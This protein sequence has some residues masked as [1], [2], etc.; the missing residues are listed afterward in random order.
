MIVIT[1]LIYTDKETLPILYGRLKDLC[2]PSRDEDGCE[3]YH[4]A[5][6]DEEN[7]TILAMEGWRDM[8][9]LETHLALPAVAKLLADFDG[10]YTNAVQI[11]Q[12]SSSQKI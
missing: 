6:E 3:F 9:A 8:A 12:V 4:M 10:K 5:M 2:A 1:G 11:H 7:C